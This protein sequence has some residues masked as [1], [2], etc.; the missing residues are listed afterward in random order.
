[1]SSRSTCFSSYCAAPGTSDVGFWRGTIPAAGLDV[2][3]ARFCLLLSF[4][5]GFRLFLS[6]LAGLCR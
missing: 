1:M 2:V 6:L 3:G 5:A 4:L